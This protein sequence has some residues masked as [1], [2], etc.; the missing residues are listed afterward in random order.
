MYILLFI[1]IFILLLYI[2][3]GETI[4]P[5]LPARK[6][7]LDRINTLAKLKEGDVFYELGCGDGRVCQYIAQKNPNCLVVGV[8]IFLPVFLLAKFWQIF[9][10]QKNLK[11]K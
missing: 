7:D 4:A 3:S 6:L 5:W 10:F 9:S 1:V 11:I 8:E 2:Y